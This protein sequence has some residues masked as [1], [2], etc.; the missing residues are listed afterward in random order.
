MEKYHDKD[1]N[2]AAFKVFATHQAGRLEFG[3]FDFDTTARAVFETNCPRDRRRIR[4]DYRHGA[5]LRPVPEPQARADLFTI[6]EDSPS[7]PT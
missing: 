2:F 4:D 6:A 1:D 3:S 5:A 7:T